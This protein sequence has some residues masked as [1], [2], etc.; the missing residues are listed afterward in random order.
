[1]AP[2]S[3][4]RS[5]KNS[6]RRGLS[7][8]RRAL[9]R[10]GASLALALALGACGGASGEAKWPQQVQ[11]WYDRGELSYRSGDLDDAEHATAEALRSLPGEAKVRILAAKIALARLD[12]DKALE[13]SEGLTS[14]EARALRGRA[15]WYKGE[16]ELAA[17]ELGSLAAD[18]EVRDPWAVEVAELARSG[19]GRKPFEMSGG[20]LA[21]VEMPR[22]G[23]SAMIVPLEVNGEPSLALVATDSSETIIDSSDKR[24]AWLSLRFGGRVEVNDV[25][26]LGR[27]LSGLKRELNAPIKLLIGVNLLRHLRPTID[28]S[29]RQFVVRSFDPPAPPDAT[30]LHPVYYRGGAIVLP[31]AYGTDEAAPLG[32]LLMHTSMNFPVALDEAAWKKVG[33]D[34]EEFAPIPGRT[35]LKEGRLPFLRLGT[36]DINGVPGVL[37]APVS[38][39]EKAAQADLDG[40]AGSGLFATFRLTLTDSGRTLWI[41][42]LPAEVLAMQKPI[43]KG[44]PLLPPAN[45]GT[46]EFAPLPPPLP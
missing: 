31:V 3:L 39:V 9:E 40:F 43:P 42:D 26:A 21:A 22:A 45:S 4:L 32:T 41:E 20:L 8:H 5:K 17:K 44:T 10:L 27:D 36:F 12:F 33:E 24:G 35:G 1:M 14:S 46:S 15:H 34:P 16:L 18:P 6:F 38:E 37:G 7:R 25:P 19:S 29:G 11:K 13:A 23:S 30:T 28:F 2:F